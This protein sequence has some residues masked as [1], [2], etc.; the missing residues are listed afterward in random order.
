MVRQSRGGRRVSCIHVFKFIRT[1]F[2]GASVYS[3]T[4][5]V[6]VRF[7]ALESIW[8]GVPD[9]PLLT[10]QQERVKIDGCPV[11]LLHRE[12]LEQAQLIAR[13]HTA[14]REVSL[15]LYPNATLLS[16]RD[17]LEHLLSLDRTGPHTHVAE[18]LRGN[19]RG[20]FG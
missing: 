18:L 5:A 16:R 15:S 14:A 17:S 7:A 12:L 2:P 19:P 11:N 13:P 8:L 1:A 9:P 4:K 20:G 10:C 3:M 6:L